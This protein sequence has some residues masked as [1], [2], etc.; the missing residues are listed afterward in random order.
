MA[1]W[2]ASQAT[3][4]EPQHLSDFDGPDDFEAAYAHAM[5][6][7]GRELV[8]EEGCRAYI[9]LDLIRRDACEQCGSITDITEQ[10][11]YTAYEP[12][13]L[14][15]WKRLLLDEEGLGEPPNPNRCPWLCP[16]CAVV[17]KAYWAEMWSYARGW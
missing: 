17:H 3:Y 7:H 16:E 10:P 13:R 1:R 15:S 8:A 5:E 2:R 12:P 9:C 4:G 14:A 11:S 6:L